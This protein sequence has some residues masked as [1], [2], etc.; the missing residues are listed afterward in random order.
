VDIAII[1][2][3]N[4]GAALAT[5]WA[6]A[7]HHIII[8]SRNADDPRIQRVATSVRATVVTPDEAAAA[9]TVVTYTI[10]GDALVPT[11]A[12]HR[13]SLAGKTIVVPANLR[14]GAIP[15]LAQAAQDA[16]PAAAII[17]AFNT[18]PWE[19][20]A[21][22]QIRGEPVD[23]LYVSS[24]GPTV[25]LAEKLIADCGLRPI[26]VGAIDQGHLIDQL[27]ALWAALAFGQ[28]RGRGFAFAV[29]EA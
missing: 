27:F 21:A 28:R 29:R 11:I 7:G 22:S 2:A 15:N 10:P 19:I 24:D 23:M 9:G 13:G 1:G 20:L 12:S 6:R 8:G 5:H 26:R 18:I 3:G 17:R 16:A 4:V 25:E 14:S